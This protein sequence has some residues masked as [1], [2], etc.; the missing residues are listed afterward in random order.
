MERKSRLALILFFVG[1]IS[2]LMFV[3]MHHLEESHNLSGSNGPNGW[4]LGNLFFWYVWII[5]LVVTHE[6]AHATVGKWQGFRIFG[7]RIGTGRPLCE[8]RIFDL[9]FEIKIW[10]FSG[11]TTLA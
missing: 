1:I 11:L 2:C 8:F 9:K 3:S 7:V 10:P 5:P 4:L 6:I